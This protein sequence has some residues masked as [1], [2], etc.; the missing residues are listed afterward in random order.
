MQLCDF[1][2][3]RFQFARDRVIGDSQVRIATANYAALELHSKDGKTGLGFAASLFEPL[4]AL[5]DLQRIFRAEAWPGLVDQPPAALIHRVSRPRGGNQ[6][7][8]TAPFEE[9][10]NQALWDLA[11]QEVG[12]PLWRYLG[13]SDPRTKVY[14]SGLDFHLSDAAYV[15]FFGAA[16]AQGY[17]GFKIKVGHRDVDWDLRRL[18]LLRETV[19]GV[20]PVMVDANEAWSPKEAIHRLDIYRRAGFEILWIE[21]PCLRDDYDGLREI[22]LACPWV[23]VNSGEYLDLRGKRRLLE[24]RGADYLNVHGHIG[25]VMKAGW[26]AAEHGVR[27]TLGNTMLELGA[28]LASAL[29]EA[30]WL[31]YSFQN[32]NHLV[33]EPFAMKD[34]FV[35]APDR[36]GHGLQLSD[37]ARREHAVP[38]VRDPRALPPAPRSSPI[39]LDAA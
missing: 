26:L 38:E 13:G 36:P 35:T 20:G 32:Y 17:R 16:K 1:T 31:E 33:A 30:D 25:D 9:A 22:R 28:H 37:A 23:L 11:A 34:G 10:I 24:G 12:L 39:T 4:P 7:R 19:G 6:R 5:S 21:D 29:P 27:V 15:A 8:M 18:A 2:I 3:T 14:A